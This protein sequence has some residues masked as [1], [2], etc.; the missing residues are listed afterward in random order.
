M[1][2]S[3]IL[4]VFSSFAT[5]ARLNGPGPPL[6]MAGSTPVTIDQNIDCAVKEL[7]WE[8]A[9]NLQPQRGDF[10]AVYDALSL[11]NCNTSLHQPPPKPVL[12]VQELF[13]TRDKV[14]PTRD[15][16][17]LYVDVSQGSDSNSGSL[18]KPVKTLKQAVMLWRDQRTPENNGIIY[19]RAGVYYFQDT[20]KLGSADSF[21][22]I[23]SYQNEVVVF[24]GG[25]E[26]QLSWKTY[27][28]EMSAIMPGI[29]AIYD[30]NVQPGQSNSKARYYGKVSKPEDCQS[31]CQKDQTC[32]I[33]TYHD[34]SVPN[35]YANM[36][37]F[38]TDSL[39]ITTPETGHYSGRKINIQ[40]ADLSSQPLINFTT[41]FVNNRRAVRAR[42]PDGNPETMGLHTDPSGYVSKADFWL[43]PRT[44]PPA[45]NI[46]IQ[47]PFRN[48]THFPD[49][50]LGIGGTVSVF[51]PPESYWG[52]SSPT[53]GGG[54]TY[55]IT[56]GLIYSV[57]EDFVNRTW[58]NPST[59]VIHA[60]HCGHWGNWQ[61]AVKSRNMNSREITWEYGGF[62]EARGC[63]NG[64]EWYVENILE[65]LDS[66][67]EWFLDYDKHIL[68]FM[69]N[70]S[71]TPTN[72]IGSNLETV[73]SIIGSKDNPARNITISGVTF[74]NTA[75]TFLQSYE[76]P[77]G[78]DWGIHRGGTL[79]V[80]GS[81]NILISNCSFYAVGGN[82]IFMN[83]YNRGTIVQGNEFK[84][85]GDSAIAAVGSSELID[86]TDGNQPRGLQ[87]VGNLA[88]E[89]GIWG[90]QTSFY[91]QSLSCQTVLSGNVFFN[92]PRA[93]INFNDGFGGG[94]LVE[95]NLGF[96]MVRETGDHGPF[97]SW[98][99]QPYLTDVN[100]LLDQPSLLSNQ[101]SL[102]RNFFI[103][104]YHSTW[105][106]DH[107]DGSCY[108]YDTFN[109]L[110]YGGYKNYLGHSKVVKYNVY[111]YPDASH[112]FRSSQRSGKN[113]GA[114][115]SK[116]FCA[117][118]DGA[119]I[120][121]LP[122]GWGEVWSNNTCIIGNPNVYEFQQCDPGNLDSRVVPMTAG[123]TFY[124]PNK[125]VYVSCK[126]KQLS[127][128][129][130]QQLGQDLGSVV[131]DASTVDAKTIA[132]WGRNL[133][134]E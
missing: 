75:P 82:G 8:F 105:P 76:V 81:E 101:S 116:P 53:G 46:N 62:Q 41:F 88:H 58:N 85:T 95:Y 74:A 39:W 79:F 16:I 34:S 25:V 37:Y 70:G 28:N 40:M 107:D 60:F 119:S 117:N 51:D 71:T 99:R 97:N 6:P 94:N 87:V 32:F 73:I 98:D 120:G 21:L 111:I 124:A 131:M 52:T 130:Y 61:F 108:Y 89:V 129:Q 24:S 13:S 31:A 113:V 134:F 30:T 86:G 69:F 29:N 45:T 1:M 132:Q 10:K 66:P 48:G 64:A 9:K 102:T 26:Y 20:L 104:N 68:Y 63:K 126:G 36:C 125:S 115:F 96:N 109:Y 91:I 128:Q 5:G 83:N 2:Y 50:N 54:S 77:S 92:G 103:N 43:P 47:S 65:E 11:Q 27:R 110:V 84:Y 17:T 42:Y 67:N 78:G 7:A 38:R 121:D 12:K 59:G 44:Y 118:S 123:N 57:N 127:L 80:E 3:L 15:T 112:F 114:F 23:S 72:G 90:K 100:V 93:G 106:I 18:D 56:Q 22:Q 55:Q 33:F 49:F 19:V 133:L 122:S 35:G 4:I 14:N